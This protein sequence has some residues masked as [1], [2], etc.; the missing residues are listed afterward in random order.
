MDFFIYIFALPIILPVSLIIGFVSLF[1][2]FG[3]LY[4]LPFLVLSI[5]FLVARFKKQAL[6]S[7]VVSLILFLFQ[8]SSILSWLLSVRDLPP[9]QSLKHWGLDLPSISTT[10]FP[11]RSIELPPP[12]MAASV[13]ADI[14]S[15]IFINNF[16]W[17][18]ISS[19]VALI[20]VF[21][22]KSKTNLIKKTSLP[23]FIIAVVILLFSITR[24]QFWFD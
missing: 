24:F 2:G 5:V 21:S 18:G 15:D 19:V 14:W 17:L 1:T 3:F 22:V 7:F 13:P 12:P 16:F 9:E 20:I 4:A 8:L 23:L 6:V 10:G 11:L